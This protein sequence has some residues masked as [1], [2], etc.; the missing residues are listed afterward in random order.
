ML[1]LV[2]SHTCAL[3]A[4][5]LQQWARICL[6]VTTKSCYSLHKQARIRAF[7][8]EGT[9]KPLLPWTV[10]A[11]PALLHIS[12]FLF[13]AGL[14]VFLWNVDLTIFKLA[15]S[16]VGIC[17]A[18]YGCITFMPI[19]RHDSP[20]STRLLLPVWHIVT[21]IR[22]L[23]FRALRRLTFLTYF[24]T[25]TYLRFSTL[26]RRSFKS[27]KQG[28]QKMF[29]ETA[30]NSPSET[31]APAFLWTFDCL[32]DDHKLERFFVGLP[33]FRSSKVVKDP[34]PSLT[35][36]G[37]QKLFEALIELLDHTISSELLPEL[38]KSR[39]AMMCK[40]AIKHAHVPFRVIHRFIFQIWRV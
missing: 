15:L 31:D 16:W 32:D 8:A 11:L 29:E 4:T 12:L 7:L 35:E 23:A 19:F 18:L 37:K 22:F 20:Y 24:I 33:G 6:K 3:L 25:E 21:E 27:L 36:E 30:L 14:V 1:S 26:A 2:I 38:V 5:L 39:R 10:E 34:L 28:T 13:F 17:T 40:K 9:E